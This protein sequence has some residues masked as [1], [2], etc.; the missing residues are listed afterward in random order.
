MKVLIAVILAILLCSCA[1]EKAR[2]L[3][4][5]VVYCQA[6]PGEIQVKKPAAA[7]KKSVQGTDKN[8]YSGTFIRK[9]AK[10]G[11]V[12]L[13]YILTYEDVKEEIEPV[14]R[15]LSKDGRVEMDEKSNLMLI[16]DHP[17]VFESIDNILKELD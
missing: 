16:T 12:T 5:R 11:L 9:D 6:D 3:S 14:K 7:E 17:E 4:D 10:T 15:L 2:I 8:N 1:G 13:C